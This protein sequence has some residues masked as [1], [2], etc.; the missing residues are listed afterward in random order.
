MGDHLLHKNEWC[1]ALLLFL[2][3]LSCRLDK[4]VRSER[5]RNQGDEALYKHAHQAEL[6]KEWVTS[7]YCKKDLDIL[8][9]SRVPTN[10][11]QDAFDPPVQWV[12][13]F[14]GNV[15]SMETP[16][17]CSLKSLLSH[18]KWTEQESIEELEDDEQLTYFIAYILTQIRNKSTEHFRSED[19]SVLEFEQ[20]RL[21]EA[22]L[23][24]ILHLFASATKVD[25]QGRTLS[26]KAVDYEITTRVWSRAEVISLMHEACLWHTHH[27][28][29]GSSS[30]AG[31]ALRLSRQQPSFVFMYLPVVKEEIQALESDPESL[32]RFRIQ[33]PSTMFGTEAISLAQDDNPRSYRCL[34]S[35]FDQGT[36]ISQDCTL[37]LETAPG[38]IREL[39]WEG[40]YSLLWVRIYTFF[41][42]AFALWAWACLRQNHRDTFKRRKSDLIEITPLGVEIVSTAVTLQLDSTADGNYGDTRMERIR[43]TKRLCLIHVA[44]SCIVG[45]ASST[46]SDTVQLSDFLDGI[47][48]VLLGFVSLNHTA[49][50]VTQGTQDSLIDTERR[51][52]QLHY[53]KLASLDMP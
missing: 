8:C 33:Y 1:V 4:A 31:A 35:H 14:P 48:I 43:K 41:S 26:T 44:A 46:V 37:A 21:V 51:Q 50:L 10:R 3:A 11:C 27:K 17:S 28:R 40:N 9:P 16:S 32:A 45:V 24:S 23:T 47:C 25:K 5:R 34:W 15:Y 18:V 38:K 30:V 22:T 36:L 6:V 39:D 19:R 52:R 42:A 13:D 12:L 49:A 20:S 2:L 7:Q 53:K 29:H